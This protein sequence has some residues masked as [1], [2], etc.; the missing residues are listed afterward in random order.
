[1][2]FKELKKLL[3]PS[4]KKDETFGF[5]I[6]GGL[7]S[8]ILLYAC[9][10]V[11]E[12]ENLPSR[13]EVVTVP[14][15]DDSSVHSARIVEWINK[16]FN[17]NL[18]TTTCGDPDVHHSRQVLSGVEIMWNKLDHLVFG[19]TANV[20]HIPDGPVRYPYTGGDDKVLQPFMKVYKDQTV[21]LAI[22]LGLTELMEIT[23]SCTSSKTLRC[24][25]CWQCKERAWAFEECKYNDPGTM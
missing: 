1:M 21:R 12:Q 10:L 15:H 5:F 14:R 23:H 2:L 22:E 24:R 3:L 19:D 9:C 4:L 17:I 6:S 20:P 11:R 18:I 25:E 8:A 13:F 7:D 16:Q